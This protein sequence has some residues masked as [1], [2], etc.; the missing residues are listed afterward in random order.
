MG[1]EDPS[2]CGGDYGSGS[3]VARSGAPYIDDFPDPVSG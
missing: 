3:E 2:R 1:G